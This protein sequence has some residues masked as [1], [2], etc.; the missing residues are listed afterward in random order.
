MSSVGQVLFA[1]F[2]DHLKAQKGLRPGSVRSYRDTLK[3]FLAHVATSRRRPIT[4]LS[5]PD[6][7][8]E[9]P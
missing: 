5:L 2:A 8:S 3:L 7:S 4:R 9:E 6:L 1:F